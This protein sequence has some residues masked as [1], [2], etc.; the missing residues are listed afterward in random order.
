MVP[1]ITAA[2]ETRRLIMVIPARDKSSTARILS[3]LQTKRKV[4]ASY[5]PQDSATRQGQSL[6][7]SPRPIN[8]I[9]PSEPP[10]LPGHSRRASLNGP[11]W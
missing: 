10:W 8:L 3:R 1:P 5:L 6:R 11:V 7:F 2:Y 9:M 4:I